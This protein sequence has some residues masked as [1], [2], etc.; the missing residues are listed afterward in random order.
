MLLRVFPEQVERA[1]ETI[2]PMMAQSLPPEVAVSREILTNNLAAVLREDLQ[3]WIA[4][5]D[6]H[7]EQKDY[8]AMMSTCIWEDPVS[9][10]RSL[11]V[12][13]LYVIDRKTPVPVWKEAIAQLKR[14][15][16]TRGCSRLV[17]FVGEN[18]AYKR[19]LEQVGG[20]L[21]TNLVVF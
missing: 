12:Y 18:K 4:V 11:M 3:V 21:S 15:G 7:A 20:D 14:Y 19:F 16:E 6:E 2:A 9:C 10:I 8:L 5:E 17:G 1:W 13:H